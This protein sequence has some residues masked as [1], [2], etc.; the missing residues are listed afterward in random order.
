MRFAPLLAILLASRAFADTSAISYGQVLSG[1]LGASERD[2]FTFTAA[3]TG[4]VMVRVTSTSG[5]QGVGFDV[6]RVGV[7]SM[8]SA[9]GVGPVST[10]VG[11]P[12]LAGESYEIRIP[13]TPTDAQYAGQSYR[14][15]LQNL[16]T[17]A[18]ATAVAIGD[19]ATGSLDQSGEADF[20]TV[21]AHDGDELLFTVTRTSGSVDP[22]AVIFLPQFVGTCTPSFDNE[23][24]HPTVLTQCGDFNADAD[25][26]FWVDDLDDDTPE[27]LG[28]TDTGAYGFTITCLSGPC[29]ANVT[30]T[31]T[32]VGSTSTGATTSTV[33]GTTTTTLAPTEVLLVDGKTLL[34]K[35]PPAKPTKKLLTML[36]ADPDIGLGGGNGS[37]DD[38]RTAGA[39]LRIRSVAAGFDTVYTLPAAGWKLIGPSGANKGYKYVDSSLGAG[40]VS[41]VVV[42]K[43][44]L[45]LTAKGAA[46]DVALATNPDPVDVVFTMGGVRTCARY[47]GTVAFAATKKFSAKL[48][49]APATCP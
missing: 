16:T 26:T 49:T 2:I 17:P 29:L 39:T 40:P 18:G 41:L 47:G 23:P 42:K 7:G 35:T 24:D 37:A 1:T 5:V 25:F 32:T 22:E 34:V 28:G 6:N 10:L 43:K 21:P 14:V 20:F 9:A 33:A 45:N 13:P 48:A 11:V 4:R 30:T 12:V 8:G 27:A 38:P 19:G 46:L 36:S 31:T 44:H 3:A 15:L